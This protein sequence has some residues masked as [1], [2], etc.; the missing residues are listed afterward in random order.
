MKDSG[1]GI[2]AENQRRLFNEIVQFNAAELQN[3]NG[4]GLGLWSKLM[5]LLCNGLLILCML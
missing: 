5:F 3:G 1:V 4:S 2:S